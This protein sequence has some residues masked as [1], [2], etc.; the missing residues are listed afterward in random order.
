MMGH[1]LLEGGAEFGGKMA[2]AD[3]RAL[4]LAGGRDARISII[5]AAAAPDNNHERAGQNGVRWFKHLG[6]THVTALPLIDR[7]SANEED[8]AEALG[9]SRFIYML[10][11]FPHY[12][13]Q[14]LLGSLSWQAILGAYQKG[15]VIAGSSAGA[16][17]LCEYYYDPSSGNVVKG[18]NLLSGACIIPHHN[19]F[20]QAWAAPLVQMRPEVL[21]IGI[22]EET[23]M[24]DDGP[25]GKW[26]IYGK[27]TVTLY[28]HHKCKRYS[29]GEVFSL[30]SE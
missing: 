16:M 9:L 30:S 11:G 25:K 23:G 22:D 21:F 1:I 8:V 10:G 2:Q 7:A 6:A 27:G 24:I 15:A 20:G 12:L 18:L 17:G 14:T 4:A 5:P 13:A 19:T 29:A 3:L 26:R 28:H